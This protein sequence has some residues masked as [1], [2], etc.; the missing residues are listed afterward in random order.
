[1]FS[2]SG[3]KGSIHRPMRPLIDD[4][5]KRSDL[6]FDGLQPSDRDLSPALRRDFSHFTARVA[7]IDLELWVSS[8]LF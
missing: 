2:A 6:Q 5:T 8:H 1:V 4:Q 7:L 3:T